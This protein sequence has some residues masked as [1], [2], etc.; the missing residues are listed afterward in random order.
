MKDETDIAAG[1]NYS[2]IPFRIRIGVTGHRKDLG[3]L[4]DL[5]YLVKQTID[6]Q[7]DNLFPEEAR[8]FIRCARAADDPPMRYSI[9]TP[10]AEGAD[11]LVA[12]AVLS[13]P[14]ARIDAVL[15]LTLE[16]YLE[17]F[18][19][20][21]S[22]EEFQELLARCARP[23]FLRQRSIAGEHP[24]PGDARSA[25]REAYAA[26]GRYVVDHCDVLIAIWDGA[27]PQ[28]PG[29]TAEIVEYARK[30]ERPL[31][32]IWPGSQ[33]PPERGTGLSE[34]GLRAMARFYRHTLTPAERAAAV[35]KR[36]AGLFGKPGK[37]E[38]P[39]VSESV[40]EMVRTV[41]LPDAVQ[42]SRAASENQRQF[43]K[44]G[45]YVFLLSAIAVACVAIAV[46]FEPLAR[47]GF[48]AE[49]VLLTVMAFTLARTRNQHAHEVWIESRFLAER[50][51]SAA[52]LAICGVEPIP[53]EVV[54]FMGHSHGEGEWTV[55]AFDEIWGRIPRLAGYGQEQCGMLRA[56]I[57]TRWIQDQIRH[58]TRK[59]EAERHS[60]ERIETAGRIL[61]PVTM[62]AA[63]LHLVLPLF[64]ESSRP[65]HHVDIGLTFIAIVFP[66]VGAS[67][68]G[69]LAQREHL[70]LLKRSESMARHLEELD[71]DMASA[72]TPARFAAVLRKMDE[73]TLRETQDWLML[74]RYVEIRAN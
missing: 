67:L 64:F 58:H 21:E 59:S 18:K 71:G 49:F 12:R 62:A 69:T 63:L 13:Y 60:R 25:R 43:F 28:K 33:D 4:A 19:T 6:T 31:I 11:R 35:Q 47:Y 44:A 48:S 34:L 24:D 39:W 52:F 30:A 3:N 16:D 45:K 55:R 14:D 23:R 70:R 29:G 51:R 36:Y 61:L 7:L 10:L 17:D 20:R 15:P 8:D 9:V 2:H 53:I 65:L 66:A 22:K 5:E 41:L 68:A 38:A 73:L 54:P 46:L 74:M 56:Y 26:V 57:R 1:V 40:K 37:D 32:R 27:P 72:D 42:A 50:L